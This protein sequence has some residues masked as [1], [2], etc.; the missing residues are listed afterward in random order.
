MVAIQDHQTP[1]KLQLAADALSRRKCKLPANL[2]RLS[3]ADSDVGEKDIID[4]LQLRLTDV[5]D[6]SAK[7]QLM[8]GETVK[9]ITRE[10][11]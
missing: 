5:Y 6:C 1:G 7:I 9:V 10:K 3:A 4:D 8:R 11:L 2:Y